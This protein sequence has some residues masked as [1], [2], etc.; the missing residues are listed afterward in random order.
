MSTA[1]DLHSIHARGTGPH[2]TPLVLVHAFPDS[3][4]RFAKVI[5]LLTDPAAHGG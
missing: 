2:P 3:F 4:Y 5:P 1:R